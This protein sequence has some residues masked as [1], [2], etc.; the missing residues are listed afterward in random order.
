[1]Q[2]HRADGVDEFA[3]GIGPPAAWRVAVLGFV[4]L[5]PTYAG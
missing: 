4:S 3:P 1:M 2:F 5:T